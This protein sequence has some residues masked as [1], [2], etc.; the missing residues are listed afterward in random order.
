MTVDSVEVH[1]GVVEQDPRYLRVAVL[2]A[3][4]QRRVSLPVLDVPVHSE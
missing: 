2:H 1:L 4:H 3:V